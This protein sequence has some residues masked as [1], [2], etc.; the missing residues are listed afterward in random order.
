MKW[1][2]DATLA[3]GVSSLFLAPKPD[4]VAKS[5]KTRFS[6]IS[7]QA[8]ARK[9]LILLDFGVLSNDGTE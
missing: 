9:Y 5:W 8:E 3:G 1:G 6:V 7:A 2:G 4:G